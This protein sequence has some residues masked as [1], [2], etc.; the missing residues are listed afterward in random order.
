MN[1]FECGGLIEIDDDDEEL[2]DFR[3]LAAEETMRK[4]GG[5]RAWNP[6]RPFRPFRPLRPA[7][8]SSNSIQ[9]Q[10]PIQLLN[11]IFQR[12]DYLSMQ[13]SMKMQ[14]W[15]AAI[16]PRC[17]NGN[18]E[19]LKGSSEMAPISKAVNN[20]VSQKATLYAADK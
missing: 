10:H 2:K 15:A 13:I 7:T 11:F 5:N 8:A 20:V 9:Q 19:W 12:L 3:L 14:R 6:L 16:V 1:R 17:N 4:S 18:V